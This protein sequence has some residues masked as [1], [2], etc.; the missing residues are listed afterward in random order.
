MALSGL[1][2]SWSVPYAVRVWVPLAF[3]ILVVL[4]EASQHRESDTEVADAIETEAPDVRIR[5]LRE[6]ASLLPGIVLGSVALWLVVADTSLGDTL[7]GIVH[8]KP[9]ESS[10]QPVFGV[11]TAVSG[12]VIA[13]GIGWSIRIVA[14]LVYAK[15]AFATGDIHMMAAAG[16]VAGWQVVAIGFM[17]TC[18]L[19]MV[20]WLA[21]LPFKKSHVIPLGPWLTFGYVVAIAFYKPIVELTVIQRFIAAAHMLF[22]QNSQ[23]I[24]FG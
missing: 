13:A 2:S 4:R 23:A 9:L 24:P 12:Y 3:M 17:V 19:A 7:V 5:T 20:A 6:L 11:A 1:G 10:W 22:L 8:W 14:N 16:A 18:S 21:L 15:E